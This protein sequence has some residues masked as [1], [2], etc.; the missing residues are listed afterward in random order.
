[1]A[2]PPQ[3]SD[4]RKSPNNRK[5]PNALATGLFSKAKKSGGSDTRS[6]TLPSP[7]M[8]KNM[9]TQ[10]NSGGSSSSSGRG[11]LQPPKSA[12]ISIP[13]LTSQMI[14]KQKKLTP[15]NTF[16]SHY[17]SISRSMNDL[18]NI[19][20]RG[21]SPPNRDISPARRGIPGSG[22][23]GAST[24]NTLP[25]IKRR[26]APDSP[27][28]KN[29]EGGNVPSISVMQHGEH[30]YI[31][32]K[33]GWMNII[34]SNSVKKGPL[35]EA[36]KLQH[37][38]LSGSHLMLYKP[39]SS[40][41]IKSFDI[42]AASAEPPRPQSAPATASPSFSMSNI[43]HKSISRHPDLELNEDEKVKGG[44]VE[45]LCHEMMF[46]KD[47]EFV[48]GAVRTLSA[49]TSA[50]A[51][52]PI[53]IELATL[54]DN[55]LRIGQLISLLVETSPGLLLEPSAYNSARLLVEKGVTPHNQVLAKSLRTTIEDR[56]A[57]LQ[58]A[59][60]ISFNSEKESS[61][62]A[63]DT[64]SNFSNALTADDFLRMQPEVFATQLQ[65]FHLKY[66]RAW[67]PE[68]DIS[69]LLTSPNLIPPTHRNPL[70]FSTTNVH[71]LAERVFNHI[72]TGESV[73]SVDRRVALLS[74]WL[75]VSKLS[76]E[77]GD[78]VAY[79]AIVM[80]L[81][82]PSIL[83]LRET[84]SMV[85]SKL[86]DDL[87]KS[88]IRALRILER[89]R[90]VCEG[91]SFEGRVF[92]AKCVGEDVPHSEAVPFFGDLCHCMDEA[93]G[94]RT[95]NI[96]YQKYLSGLQAVLKGLEAWRERWNESK[97]ASKSKERKAPK[98]IEQLQKCFSALVS[99]QQGPVSALSNSF[100][101]MSLGCEPSASGMY[102]Q[103]HYHQ[104][105]PL[106]SG[107][108][109]PLVFTDI[110]PSFSLFDRDDT[111]AI[112]GTLHK[113]TPSSG[114]ASPSVGPGSNSGPSQS[115]Q[116]LR[117]PN[118]PNAT[119]PS[120]RR[121]RSFPPS[122][123]S[124]QTTGYDELDFTTRERAAG[125][126]SGDNAMLRA[127]RDVAGVA[128]QL[129]H[130][131]DGE[132]VLK[133]ITDDRTTS[134]PSSVI[135]TAS[136]R[137]SVASRRISAQIHSNSTSPRI[138]LHGD[139][140]SVPVTP[141]YDDFT[142]E[143]TS[144]LRV[145]AKGGTLE[146]LVDILVLGVEDFSRRMSD[147]EKSP[148]YSDKVPLLRMNM[149]LFTIT[150]FATFRSYCSPI[151]LLDYLKKR[152]LGAK[153]AA[154]NS[155]N[156]S[157][158]V[159]FPDWTGVDSVGDDQVDW[160]L[161]AKIHMGILEAINIW[162]TEFDVDFHCDQSL[163]DSFISFME[164]ASRELAHWKN[165]GPDEAYLRSQAERIKELWKQLKDNFEKALLT[166]SRYPAAPAAQVKC[167]I[168]PI[169]T[170][171]PGIEDF[172]ESLDSKVREYFQ[173]VKLV[174]WM[175]AFE[176]F[177]SQSADPLGFFAS[178][179][180]LLSHEEDEVIQDI[181]FLL[182]SLRRG[183][184][185]Q[186]LLDAL[187][188]TLRDLC[189]LHTQMTNWILSQLV[190]PKMSVDKRAH[191]IATLL[192]CLTICRKRMSGMDLYE[193]SKS[194][195][196]QHVPSFVASAIAAA[197]VR[198]ESRMYSYAWY[199]GVKLAVGPATQI[200]SLEQV[201]PHKV[202]GATCTKTM[203]PCTGWI[204]ERLLEIICYVPNM[205]VENNR[206]INFDKRRYVYN[207]IHNF[208]DVSVDFPSSGEGSSE[209][210]T[211]SL[212][213][214][215]SFDMKTLRDNAI[216][217]NQVSKS[218]R[219]K[220]FWRLLHQEQEK[221]RRDTKQRDSIE[222]Q[223]R[224]QQR[225]ETRRQPGSMGGGLA[226]KKGG[227]RLGVNTLIKAVRPISMALTSS[228]TPP[229][230]NNRT[231]APADLPILKPVEPGR[232]PSTT[233][234]LTTVASISCPPGTRDRFMWKVRTE[235]GVSYLLQATNERELEG[236]LKII[237]SV[238]GIAASDG[239]ESVDAL[240]M[241][242]ST[243]RIPQPVFGISL[244]DLCRR[245]KVKVPLVVESLL[246]EIELRGLDEVGIYRVP[247][248]MSSINA[249]KVALDSSDD[250]RMDDDRWYDI[251]AIAGAFKLFM[252]ELPDQALGTEALN[253]LRNITSEISEE[254]DR[255]V[256]YRE[257]MSQLPSYNYN[258]LRRVYQHFAK[259]AANASINKMHAVNLA[260]VF[261]MGLA[262]N[263]A[264]PLGVSPDLGLYQTM[265]KTWITHADIIFADDGEDEQDSVTKAESGE[266]PSS[267]P[268][269]PA[270]ENA[271]NDSPRMSIDGR[272]ASVSSHGTDKLRLEAA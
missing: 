157:D 48:R 139:S 269:S 81:L 129:F 184:S 182:D 98:E 111:L 263:L 189:A 105:L 144:H 21:R 194:G 74:H 176:L 167:L 12:P 16:N 120:L 200:D 119:T 151:V 66:L 132:L 2:A 47:E 260:I 198:P 29:M 123:A 147:P 38:V 179:I 160:N 161:V 31:I 108:N 18:G 240:T 223:Q 245:D 25:E 190:D 196:R 102:L 228:W 219:I 244:G 146:R 257:V 44:T 169:H 158:D 75:K 163:G 63:I 101:D 145:V 115:N 166:P 195:S 214:P 252:R 112:S 67:S 253:M 213:A 27:R 85:D 188:K 89:R 265:V 270:L 131:K 64:F 197:L 251:N 143:R 155:D 232:K 77:K 8:M 250:V 239:A 39:P 142:F 117:P 159:V 193:S 36:W 185:A 227:K 152:L 192:K 49:W 206:L 236:W 57:K 103:S 174:D 116:N 6:P 23:V 248:S 173:G 254:E 141:L 87:E 243:H 272:S 95:R 203:T 150:F 33:E 186:T 3:F 222:R 201:I 83:R 241:M 114:L 32:M 261:G 191:R 225:A 50:E 86:V 97:Q 210:E 268:S 46:T 216:K 165:L 127:I 60:D 208:T 15:S 128:Q 172:V 106:S 45:A 22:G 229:Q 107:A 266:M 94:S 271:S 136:K 40:Y 68:S 217:E 162:V 246:G 140:A 212:S 43:R 199:L 113:K 17:R 69:V 99:N 149:D 58:K 70:I 104:R 211:I 153:S 256:A 121:V 183:N 134:R 234:D 42:S 249:L 247:G 138:S 235:N 82:A 126:H 202:E 62:P 125:L 154:T 79:L 10:G 100:F 264:S 7:T 220:V 137:L 5:P 148:T 71:F 242:S 255:I 110:L 187:P 24:L 41:Q 96:D 226:E 30:G 90:L 130:S 20:T 238:R 178:K 109:V 224:Y 124:S 73:L 135:E 181:F 122:K 231:V 55:S 91:E 1:M 221:L 93:Y 259:V 52:L 209:M 180:S 118:S 133:A 237:A 88:G 26:A 215:S 204:I 205:V 11:D 258:F 4:G 59:L 156:E 34:D 84:W 72:L 53:F 92:I 9:G 177:E 207:F 168:I 170:D 51:A 80:A 35:R 54:K 78:M 19:F 37:A 76:R 164:I 28:S 56:V 171:V 14:Q 65:L 230:S 175:V 233:I 13:P 61:T 262:P 218:G 267:E